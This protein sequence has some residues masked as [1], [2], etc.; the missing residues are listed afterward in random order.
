MEGLITN[1]I[2]SLNEMNPY[3]NYLKLAINK[4]VHFL[5]KIT[6]IPTLNPTLSTSH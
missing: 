6:L 5:V 2:M 4:S 3:L 1:H